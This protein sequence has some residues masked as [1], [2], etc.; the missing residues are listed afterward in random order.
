MKIKKIL[1]IISKKK[2]STIV[3]L[4]PFFLLSPLILLFIYLLKPIFLIRFDQLPSSRIGHFAGEPELYCCEKDFSINTPKK[5]YL[6]LFF[7]FDTCNEQLAKMWKRKLNIISKNVLYPIYYINSF[8]SKFF[9][10]LK[11]HNIKISN[12]ARDIHDLFIKSKP[13]ISFNDEEKQKGLKF[14]KK[15]NLNEDS[16]FV[17]L[18]VRDSLYLKKAFNEKKRAQN[19]NFKT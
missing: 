7:C 17:C 19:F 9:P 11:T 13:H 5:P 8:L 1:L 6:D 12:K 10:S 16:K 3:K 2:L 14:L 18:F 15:F 4:L